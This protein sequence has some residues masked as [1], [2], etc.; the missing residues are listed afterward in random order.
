MQEELNQLKIKVAE[1]E[2]FV[3]SLRAEAT[4]PYDVGEAFK[5][6]LGSNI[7]AGVPNSNDNSRS[8]NEAGSGTYFVTGVQSGTIPF[9]IN[10][11][12]YNIL[13]Y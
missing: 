12:T 5:T 4:I 11:T 1:L 7:T 2:A 9:N 6:R 10:G 8:V 13:Y 3:Q